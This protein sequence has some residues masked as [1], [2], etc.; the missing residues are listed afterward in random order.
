MLSLGV[1]R[2]VA[3]PTPLEHLMQGNVI[4]KNIA[5]R[6]PA[7]DID[8]D[9]GLRSCGSECHS[10]LG[11]AA[12]ARPGRGAVLNT[13][14]GIGTID[15]GGKCVGMISLH[16]DGLVAFPGCRATGRHLQCV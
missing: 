9:A 16:I 4:H 15:I 3:S 2:N 14:V 8:G 6:I 1:Q 11:I 12:T 10:E 5:L 13:Q 7:V